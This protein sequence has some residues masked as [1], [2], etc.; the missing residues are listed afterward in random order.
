MGCPGGR[1]ARQTRTGGVCVFRGAG[2]GCSQKR[3]HFIGAEVGH[4]EREAGAEGWGGCGGVSGGGR[5]QRLGSSR[6]LVCASLGTR[7][8]WL[9]EVGGCAVGGVKVTARR[10]P[11]ASVYCPAAV[12][13]S[14][15]PT[16][17]PKGP[18]GSRE[19]GGI[20]GARQRLGS[21]RPPPPPGGP[22]FTRLQ[23]CF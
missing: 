7:R 11:R 17:C 1:M 9:R 8:K 16:P 13:L 19:G 5:G 6:P 2:L 18:D 20:D 22:L 21:P 4:P 3:G 10:P 12:S 23:L 15:G 14:P